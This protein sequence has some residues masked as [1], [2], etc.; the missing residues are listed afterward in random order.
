MKNIEIL[1][2]I[3]SNIN[4]ANFMMDDIEERVNVDKTALDALISA[5]DEDIYALFEVIGNIG[6]FINMLTEDLRQSMGSAMCEINSDEGYDCD[7]YYVWCEKLKYNPHKFVGLFESFEAI[8]NAM[9][10]YIDETIRGYRILTQDGY[11][12][13]E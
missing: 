7:C 12:T 6:S 8:H 10:I 1:V 3:K 4:L 5:E 13:Q 11:G 2:A 9:L